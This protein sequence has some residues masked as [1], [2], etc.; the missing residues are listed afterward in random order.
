MQN[1]TERILKSKY[2]QK[3][4]QKT[5]PL[6]TTQNHRKI[7]LTDLCTEEKA[8][9]GQLI[10]TLETRKQENESLNSSYQLALLKIR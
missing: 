4:K 9:V 7:M 2:L 6:L 10:K 1:S 3:E 8:K 5:I